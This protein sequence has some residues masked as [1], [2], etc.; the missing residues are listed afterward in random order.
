MVNP[1]FIS[2]YGEW[3]LVTGASDGIGREIAFGLAKRGLNLILCSRRTE[4]LSNISNEITK[5]FLVQV[6][7]A[8]H[9]LSIDSEIE[10]LFTEIQDKEIGLFVAAAGFGTS[11]LFKD[12]DIHNELNM[13]DLNCRSVVKMSHRFAGEFF[14]KQ[15]GGIILFSS[16]VAFQGTP[17][18]AN[19]SATK[20]FIQNFAEGLAVELAGSGVDVLSVA[21]GPVQSGF[22]GRANMVMGNALDPKDVADEIIKALGR[23]SLVRPGFL[24][25]ALEYAL[26]LLIFR[27]ARVYMMKIVMGG[28]TRHQ[29][30]EVKFEK[31]N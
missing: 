4:V 20:A 29:R 24:S 19:Y 5:R 3:A 12:S 23:K 21:P 8:S 13:I 9:D 11:G 6:Q 14:E 17:F 25:K 28:M 31:P 27:K 7:I 22:S 30:S 18:S 1:K 10:S 26:K 16:L 2:K 15:K